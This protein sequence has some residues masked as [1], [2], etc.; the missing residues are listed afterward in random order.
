M[1]FSIFNKKR[2]TSYSRRIILVICNSGFWGA[3]RD[4]LWAAFI[5]DQYQ[6]SPR[7][8]IIQNKLFADDCLLYHKIPSLQDQLQLQKDITPLEN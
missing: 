2:T 5:F 6:R 3:P 8:S 1:I 4:S 7:G